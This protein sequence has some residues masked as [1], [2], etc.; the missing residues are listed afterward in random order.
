MECYSD[1][2]EYEHPHDERFF[3]DT[4]ERY[5]TLRA[6]IAGGL[7]WTMFL[8]AQHPLVGREV[9]RNSHNATPN[10]NRARRPAS[11]AKRDGAFRPRRISCDAR[12]P[13]GPATARP[14]RRARRC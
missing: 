4:A 7:G 3:R 11:C 12:A 5:A 14:F 9:R 8:L 6:G 1:D 10:F 13:R 2:D